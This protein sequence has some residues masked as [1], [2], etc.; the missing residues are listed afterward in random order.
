[1]SISNFKIGRYNEDIPF[2]D[3]MIDLKGKGTDVFIKEVIKYIQVINIK[4]LKVY[5]KY[6]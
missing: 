4:W 2:F 1:M 3:F 5:D 6:N